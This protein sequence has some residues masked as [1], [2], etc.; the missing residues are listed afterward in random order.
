MITILFI[1]FNTPVQKHS[2][3]TDGQVLHSWELDTGTGL[4]QVVLEAD[5][6]FGLGCRVSNTN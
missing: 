6:E 3:E 1:E 4:P 5:V 2:V